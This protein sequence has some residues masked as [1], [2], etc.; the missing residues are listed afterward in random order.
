MD[1]ERSCV[2][3][4]YNIYLILST[5]SKADR[6]INIF[7]WLGYMVSQ[8]DNQCEWMSFH[9]YESSTSTDNLIHQFN[10]V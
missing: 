7:C 6:I 1:I 9:R 10:F 2:T 5:Y 3:S 8:A 4:M